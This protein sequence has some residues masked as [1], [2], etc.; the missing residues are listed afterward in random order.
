[1]R[2]VLFRFRGRPVHSYPVMLYLAIVLGI[3]AQLFAVR[4]LGIDA[5]ATLAVTLILAAAALLGARLLFVVPHWREFRSQPG[6]IL[7]FSEGGASMYGGVLLAVPISA[8]VLSLFGLSFGA[9]WD[10]AAFTMLVGLFVGRIGCFLSGC[11]AGREVHRLG[12][13][14]PNHHGEWKRRIPAQALD[15]AWTAIVLAGALALWEHRPF[16]GALLPYA[17]GSYGAGRLV[18]ETLRESQDRIAGF[19]IQHAISMFFIVVALGTFAIAG[20]S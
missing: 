9:Y 17:V 12:A 6:R 3:Y 5:G 19:S 2:P 10:T 15:A 16:P 18:L 11:C 8:P 20:Y 7:R 4:S 1:M 13:W 14:M